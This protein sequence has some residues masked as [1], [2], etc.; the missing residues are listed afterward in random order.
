MADA[1]CQC[2]PTYMYT[3]GLYITMVG[4]HLTA[5]SPRGAVAV[6]ESPQQGGIQER[7]E[8]PCPDAAAPA[9]RCPAEVHPHHPRVAH[10]VAP[11]QPQLTGERHWRRPAPGGARRREPRVV[12][13]EPEPEGDGVGQRGGQDV[14]LLERLRELQPKERHGHGRRVPE[15]LGGRPATAPQPISTQQKPQRHGRSVQEAGHGAGHRSRSSAKAAMDQEAR[16]RSAVWA[17][18]NEEIE[19]HGR[20]VMYH[21]WQ[22]DRAMDR[23]ELRPLRMNKGRREKGNGEE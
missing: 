12:Q 6:K 7:T 22:K 17:A 19:R 13:S 16:V 10:Q 4:N 23:G 9:S 11:Q 14:Q 1:E 21:C 8:H 18:R 20:P 2:R 5:L 15:H 3:K